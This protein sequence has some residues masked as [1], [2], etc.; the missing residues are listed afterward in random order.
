MRLEVQDERLVARGITLE[1]MRTF[2]FIA[3]EGGFGK[4]GELL[5]RTQS[6][7]STSLR[8][9]EDD[10]GCKLIERRQGHI[11]GLTEEGRQLLPAARDIL[12][13]TSRAVNS[14][15]QPNLKGRVSLGVPDDFAIENLNNIISL[16]IEENPDLRVEVTSASSPTLSAM[17]DKQLLDIIILK[18]VSGQPVEAESDKIIRTDPLYWVSAEPVNFDDIQEIPLV[19]FLDG[20]AIRE[21]AITS[22]NNV[23]RSY[24]FSYTSSSFE[25]IKSAIQNRLGVGVLPRHSLSDDLYILSEHNGAPNIPSVQFILS[26]TKTGELYENFSRYLTSL[27]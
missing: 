20:C 1:Q 22:L 4:A 7:L 17:A 5:G 25:N 12:R 6:T 10:V 13:R 19:T 2:V 27:S 23:N 14:L 8:R 9:L 11:V 21:C 26:I 16:C 24:Y 15:K 18:G 3:E